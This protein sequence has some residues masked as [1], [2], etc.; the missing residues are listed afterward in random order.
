M[1]FWLVYILTE[2]LIQYKLIEEGY[3]PNYL[4]LFFIRGVFSLF[5]AFPILYVSSLHEY[6]TLL[7]FQICTFW[8]LFDLILNKLRGK[9]WSYKGE[10]S[11]WLDKIDYTIYYKLKSLAL[12]GAIVSYI[13]G[14]QF[15]PF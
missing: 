13:L 3:K 10:N 1:I 14:L 7:I 6:I 8:V 2:A 9:P 4:T 5:H 12:F 15:F 11:G